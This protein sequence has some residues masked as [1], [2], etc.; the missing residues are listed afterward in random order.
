M[1]LGGT[2]LFSHD[3]YCSKSKL[4]YQTLIFFKDLSSFRWTIDT[5]DDY[6][7]TIEIYNRLFDTNSIFL[8][9]D[10]YQ[11]LDK[12]PQLLQINNEVKKSDLYK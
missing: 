5:E 10:I 11:I 8:T 7:F 9:E 6:L 3:S 1:Q 4:S 12:N 2:Y